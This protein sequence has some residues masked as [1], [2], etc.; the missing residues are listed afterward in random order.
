MKTASYLF[1]MPQGLKKQKQIAHPVTFGFAGRAVHVTRF[2]RQRFAYLPHLLL[3]A[4]VP[5]H[6]GIAGVFDNLIWPP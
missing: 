5:T 1:T 3:A 6:Q 2:S 4:L